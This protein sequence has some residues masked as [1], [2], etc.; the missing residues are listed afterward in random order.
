M[1]SQFVK[2]GRVSASKREPIELPQRRPKPLDYYFLLLTGD[3]AAFLVAFLLGLLL[4][5]G[6]NCVFAELPSFGWAKAWQILIHA[7]VFS[8]VFLALLFRRVYDRR[9]PFWEETREIFAA[10][11]WGFLASFAIVSLKK[12]SDEVSRL[13]IGFTWIGLVFLLPLFRFYWKPYLYRFKR[14]R[15]NALIIGTS[16]AGQALARAL[17]D[18]PYLGYHVLGFLDDDNRHFGRRLNGFKVFGPVKQMGKFVRLVNVEAVFIARTAFSAVRMAEVYALA[19]RLAKEIYV[20]PE[21]SGLGML[22]AELSCLFSQRL[23]VLRIRNNLLLTVNRYLKRLVDL[24]LTVFLLPFILPVMGFIALLI[25]LD[26]PGPVLFKQERVGEGGRRFLIYKFRT[27]YVNSEEV[28]SEYLA[29]N[30]R[31][32]REWLI[33]RKLKD[34]PRVTR[35]GR[36]LRKFSLDELPQF[37]NI[38]RGEM[39]LVGPRPVPAEELAYYGENVHFYLAVKPGLTGLW[40]VSGRNLLSYEERVHLDVWYVLNW[41]LWLDLIILARTVS[42]VI[43][44]RGSF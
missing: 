38:L 11:F 39:A 30:P 13:T 31:A 19:Q 4:R 12:M 34:D 35:V 14:Y 3:V 6:L 22:N 36:L 16:P 37:F 27:M 2:K 40:Q 44:Q 15:S 17:K 1:E 26:S 29:Q 8:P 23:F 25:K 9:L 32:R 20:V 42:T 21:F 28:L 41:S 5:R 43:T 7:W 10:L 24:S 18:E 33:Y